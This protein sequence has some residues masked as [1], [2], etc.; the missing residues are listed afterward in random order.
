[1]PS[2]FDRHYRVP[3]KFTPP[4]ST[5]DNF[6]QKGNSRTKKNSLRKKKTKANNWRNLARVFKKNDRYIIATWPGKSSPPWKK[7]GRKNLERA[8]RAVSGS[9]L[10]LSLF[11]VHSVPLLHGSSAGK[12]Q[13]FLGWFML[14]KSFKSNNH[15]ILANNSKHLIDQY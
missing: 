5:P 12:T 9:E 2:I 14:K 7:E 13:P 8:K 6:H 15:V 1:M 4:P 3:P 11:C 10:L